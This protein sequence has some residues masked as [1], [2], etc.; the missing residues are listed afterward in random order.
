MTCSHAA[1]AQ[2]CRSLMEDSFARRPVEPKTMPTTTP[3]NH[4]LRNQYGEPVNVD[5]TF[6]PRG[7]KRAPSLESLV[8]EESQNATS[9]GAAPRYVSPGE[10]PF[11]TVPVPMTGRA[12]G[13]LSPAINEVRRMKA[14]KRQPMGVKKVSTTG[15]AP[16]IWV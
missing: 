8:K 6:I 7:C 2:C 15:P 5:A 1:V 3:F 10:A 14:V 9:A 12:L 16:A 11:F 4:P 13:Q